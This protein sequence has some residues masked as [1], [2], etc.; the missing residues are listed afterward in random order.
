M[1]SC[2]QNDTCTCPAI[3]EFPKDIFSNEQRLN[4]AI[5][6]HFAAA[7]YLILALGVI[8]DDYFVPV[9]EVICQK[10]KLS[11]DVAGATF[12]AAG[13]SSPEFFANIM[14][15]FITESDLGIGT[16]LG[17]AVFNIF[18]V[19]AVCGLFSGRTIPIDW[20]P[21]SRDCFIY[22]VTVIVLIIVVGDGVVY[23]YE[24]LAMIIG[25]LI[26]ILLMYFNSNIEEGAHRAM[27][28]IRSRVFPHEPTEST[29]LQQSG[30]T[31]NANANAVNNNGNSENN[32]GQIISAISRN[33]YEMSITTP[34]STNSSLME[35]RP[36]REMN[37][38]FGRRSAVPLAKAESISDDAESAIIGRDDVKVDEGGSSCNSTGEDGEDDG[39]DEV[40]FPWQRPAG[41]GFLGETFKLLFVWYAVGMGT[42][43]I[44]EG[45]P[46][47][48]L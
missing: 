35:H 44:V 39:H 19:I 4:G 12:M 41:K 45:Y 26:Y 18:G 47:H 32:G 28:K 33:D 17:S 31:L 24:S 15:T 14:G 43:G 5:A 3:E 25:Y 16:I 46:Y 37:N 34:T 23:W 13:T 22:G 38:S 20:Y 9:L 10:F 42:G 6:V 21:I 30:T 2:T 8:C 48:E 29:P 36:T 1:E 7:I 11:D 27:K 40:S